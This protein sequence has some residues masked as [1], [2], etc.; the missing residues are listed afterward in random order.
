MSEQG[1]LPPPQQDPDT[2]KKPDKK[3]LLQM[4]SRRNFLIKGSAIL[5]T[6][7][8]AAT[9]KNEPGIIVNAL[10]GLP[11]DGREL[12]PAK[13]EYATI[14]REMS[15]KIFQELGPDQFD[16]ETLNPDIFF[17]Y[18]DWISNLAY[19]Y[20]SQNPLTDPAEFEKH[21]HDFI[22]DINRTAQSLGIGLPQ[23]LLGFRTSA[24]NIGSHRS[25]N[26]DVW[27][28]AKLNILNR[29]NGFI[30]RTVTSEDQRERTLVN[31]WKAADAFE[32]RFGDP[33]DMKTYD[34]PRVLGPRTFG[35][36]D[37]ESA[38]IARALLHCCEINPWFKQQLQPYHLTDIAAKLV[39]SYTS[40]DLHKQSV[41]QYVSE[42]S[43][44]SDTHIVEFMSKLKN[45]EFIRALITDPKNPDSISPWQLTRTTYPWA[46]LSVNEINEIDSIHK[47][48]NKESIEEVVSYYT[49]E[50]AI[51]NNTF[52]LSQLAN[53]QLRAYLRKHPH[54]DDLSEHEHAVF[55]QLIE[56][57]DTC[58]A[59]ANQS[60]EMSKKA[61]K[62]FI[63]LEHDPHFQVL[64]GVA[65]HKLLYDINKPYLESTSLDN[66][67]SLS[68]LTYAHLMYAGLREIGPLR[69]LAKRPLL[70]PA[71]LPYIP[72]DVVHH[73]FELIA[74][75]FEQE[76][77]VKPEKDYEKFLTFLRLKF[78]TSD[79]K[80]TIEGKT[81]TT[82]VNS[83]VKDLLAGSA[84]H[85]GLQDIETI[86]NIGLRPQPPA[87][88]GN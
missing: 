11:P 40:I 64:S 39:G 82:R 67:I 65:F 55:Q 60:L 21:V 34:I 71:D 6:L 73:F 43:S 8:A 62:L 53:P 61:D 26:D 79:L 38:Q 7:A 45:P 27:V 31:M 81:T 41:M 42:I 29:I 78:E 23:V 70:T 44:E 19:L 25:Y 69:L 3:E 5:A 24:F 10:G 46:T 35:I 88:D 22:L 63:D 16:P 50:E 20:Y 57:S 68:Q 33:V 58:I 48:D 86:Y 66:Q 32:N 83:E 49:S 76:Q 54:R 9:V 47:S 59:L 36:H 37:M 13:P 80:V 74:T 12:L 51:Q 77:G 15:D 14:S 75:Q 84:L 28:E 85:S 18:S 17:K 4:P 2:S 52:L 87:H 72:A 56:K 30:N 1:D